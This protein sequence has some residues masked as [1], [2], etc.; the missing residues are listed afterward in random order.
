MNWN[1]LESPSIESER[2]VQVSLLCESSILSMAGH[3]E[4]CQN[5]PGPPGKA[6]Y[7][8]E[9]DSGP[10]LGRKGE[11]NPEQGSEIEPETIRL[12]PVGA[13]S[14]CDGVPIE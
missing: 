3:E 1:G 14:C 2:L 8:Q 6:K 7:S 10:V 13:A 11:K 5:Q 9:T 12:Q 4:S